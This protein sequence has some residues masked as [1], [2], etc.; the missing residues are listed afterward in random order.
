MLSN[1]LSHYKNWVEK[2]VKS[3]NSNVLGF[4]HISSRNIHLVR[5][6]SLGDEFTKIGEEDEQGW[7]KGRLKDG[8]TGLYPANYVE[9]IQ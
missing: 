5:L 9:D 2:I 7:C 4:C 1:P 3:L 8:K 6:L